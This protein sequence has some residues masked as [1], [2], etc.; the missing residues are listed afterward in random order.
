MIMVIP[1][2]VDPIQKYYLQERRSPTTPA[3]DIPPTIRDA[4]RS[5]IAGLV[6]DFD[7]T[8][9]A[10]LD[11]TVSMALKPAALI[12]SPDSAYLQQRRIL[13]T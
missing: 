4:I 12:V 8:N 5:T 9:T 1:V 3:T 2:K 11:T 13:I 6:G 7:L 10:V